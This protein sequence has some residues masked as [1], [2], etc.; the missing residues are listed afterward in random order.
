MRLDK[1]SLFQGRHSL[2]VVIETPR[3][4][5]NKFD[6]DPELNAMTLAKTLPEGMI[7]P[8]DFGFFPGTKGQDGDPLDVLV[9][10]DE[11][12]YP[13]CVVVCRLIGV[14]EAE[15]REKDGHRERNDRFIAVAKASL[16]FGRLKRPEDLPPHLLAQSFDFFVNYNRIEGK[17]FKPLGFIGPGRALSL[18]K[19][20]R[21][22][23]R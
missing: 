7:F 20:S 4:S 1:I 12:V 13:G 15:Q 14:M 16:R 8:F 10:M 2:R 3:G 11:P 17:Q 23:S 9:L 5:R 18:V 19:K 22:K 21:T 6:Y